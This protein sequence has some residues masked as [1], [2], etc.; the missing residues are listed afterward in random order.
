MNI[1]RTWYLYNLN[2][3]S[4]ILKDAQIEK[5]FTLFWLSSC[6]REF[7]YIRIV[8]QVRMRVI[9]LC[10]F[11]I[12]SASFSHSTNMNGSEWPWGF[13]ISGLYL[14]SLWMKHACLYNGSPYFY[15]T[16]CQHSDSWG[17]R[18]FLWLVTPKLWTCMH[19]HHLIAPSR[20][21]CTLSVGDIEMS[22]Y[23]HFT[24]PIVLQA[25][26]L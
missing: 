25:R 15:Q 23:I 3:I 18:P 14:K 4:S 1:E 20:H 24:N 11:S 9:Y 12:L 8:H 13:S 2:K 6:D 5:R 19:V 26:S 17:N 22:Q 21:C 7:C 16:R 10:C